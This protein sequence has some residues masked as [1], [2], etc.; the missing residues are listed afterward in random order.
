MNA[1]EEKVLELIGEDVDSPDVFLDTDAGMQPIRDSLSD[2]IQEIVMLTGSYKR[3]YL[4]PLREGQQFY[5]IRLSGGFGWVT[6]AWDVTNKRRLEQTDLIKLS[7]QNPRWMV[8]N[9]DPREYLQVGMDIVGFYPKPSASS[10]MV[11]LTLVEIPAPY[12][13]ERDRLKLRDSFQY[14][15]VNY[16]VAEFWASR[17]DAFEA[18]K[19][20]Q[21]Y[22][23]ALGLKTGYDQQ[24]ERQSAFRTQKQ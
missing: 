16:A 1:L 22:A 20:M 18:M 7:A 5:R 13:S 14:A 12:T 15:A 8:D 17:G 19:H 24:P 6:D 10:N 23:G 21:L 4:I 9:A 3:P 2:A 11:E